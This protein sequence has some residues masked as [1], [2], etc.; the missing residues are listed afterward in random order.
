MNTQT[1][2]SDWRRSFWTVA[3][4]IVCGWI[5]A[6]FV[7]LAFPVELLALPIVG[8][9][10]S[11]VVTCA[12]LMAI[13]IRPKSRIEVRYVVTTCVQLL[14][15]VALV[16]KWLVFQREWLTPGQALAFLY[17]PVAV[18]LTLLLLSRP[19]KDAS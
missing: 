5:A 19:W 10:T 3:G 15:P 11:L 8:V 6:Q 16:S 18:F 1:K 9:G 7:R 2:N 14:G 12:Y 13:R 17:A 4:I